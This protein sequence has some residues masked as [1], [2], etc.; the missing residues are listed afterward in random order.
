MLIVVLGGNVNPG[1]I[2]FQ[3]S[4]GDQAFTKLE[5]AGGKEIWYLANPDVETARIETD[6]ASGVVKFFSI[7]FTGSKTTAPTVYSSDSETRSNGQVKDISL[8][9]T[10]ANIIVDII[11]DNAS[12]YLSSYTVD[13]SQTQIGT[14][15]SGLNHDIAASYKGRQAGGSTT[16]SWTCNM[17]ISSATIYQSAVAIEE[18]FETY[19]KANSVRANITQTTTKID[20]V[21]FIFGGVQK[22]SVRANILR[23]GET[24]ANSVRANITTSVYTRGSEGSLPGNDNDLGTYYSSSEITDVGT[25]DGTRVSQTGTGFVIHQYKKPNSNNTDDI[26]GDW[27]GQVVIPP[28][29]S[30]VYLQIYNQN[31]TTWETL[32]SDNTTAAD[33]DFSLSGTKTSSVSNYYDANYWVSFRVYQEHK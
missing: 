29:R 26:Q 11:Y 31:S 33:T 2:D 13:G 28:A 3:A 24:K 23:T 21:E 25:D 5:D 6:T 16:L 14:E 15:G 4:G 19:T 30:T 10:P 20:Q 1:T 22:N 27:N 9:P 17:S 7:S 18:A 8:S 32:D 12:T